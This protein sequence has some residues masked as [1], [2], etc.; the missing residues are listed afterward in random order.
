MKKEINYMK[1]AVRDTAGE[2]QQ[3]CIS[4]L[5]A[6]E[7]NRKLHKIR[8]AI[9]KAITWIAGILFIIGACS[10]DSAD[11]TIPVILTVASGSWLALIGLANS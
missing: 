2:E 9:L 3:V 1:M 8:I 5:K 11:I 6:L 10:L 7:Q 4:I